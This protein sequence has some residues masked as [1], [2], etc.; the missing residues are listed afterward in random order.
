MTTSL[1]QTSFSSGE[2]APSLHA[3]TDLAKY[4]T[5]A[6]TLLN[7][8]VHA[9]GGASNRAGTVYVDTVENSADNTRLI[10]FQFS[11]TQSYILVFGDYTLRF[12]KDGA[13][14]LDGASP[15]E[16]ATPYAHTDLDRIH[17]AQ[18]ADVMYLA[19]PGY[20]PQKLSR[21]ADDNWTIA[22]V[23]PGSGTAAPANFARSVGTGT[24]LTLAVTATVNGEESVL[25]DT[26]T[27]DVADTVS[28]D[29]ILNVDFYSIYVQNNG[30][31]AFLRDVN[32]STWVVEDLSPDYNQ[33]P[34]EANNPFTT[35]DALTALSANLLPVMAADGDVYHATGTGWDAE[36]DP[37]GLYYGTL[38]QG[39]DQ[40]TSTYFTVVGP[41]RAGYPPVI[42]FTPATPVQ[43]SGIAF[44]A[45]NTYLVPNMVSKFFFEGYD[46]ADWIPLIQVSSQV[47]W[48]AA[49][50]RVFTFYNQ[51]AYE[52]YR[53]TIQQAQTATADILFA[54]IE[55][56][57]GTYT[58]ATNNPGTVVFHQQ[59]LDWA[60]TDSKPNTVFGSQ[61]GNFENHNT[62]YPLR[63]DDAFEF[64]INSNQVNEINWM[65]ALT[66]LILGTTGGEWQMSGGGQL[67]AI[68]P[69]NVNIVNQSQWGSNAI[70]PVRIGNTALFVQ[71]S[72]KV[73]RDLTFSFEVD[74]YT[75]NDLT[76]L[77]SHLFRNY[78]IRAWAYQQSPDSILWVVRE[79]GVL[80]GLTYIREH[81][82]WAW[83]RHETDG[84]FESVASYRETDGTDEVYF[85]VRRYIDGSYVRY[86]ERL[87]ERLPEDDIEQAFFVDCGL[88]LDAPYTITAATA[89]NPVV[90]TCAAHPFTNGQTVCI[91]DVVGMTELNG[92]KFTVANKATNTFELS[93]VDGSAYTAYQ[94]G[95]TARLVV[96]AV[97]GLD[98]LEGEDVAV[99]ADGGV[100]N[101]LTVSGGAITLP[102]GASI[103]HVG[104]PYTSDIETLEL[105]AP[106]GETILDKHRD[107]KSVTV[108]L[109]NTRAMWI[110][111]N[112][113]RLTEM[114]VRS[115]EDYGD[116]TAL[117]TG[118][119]EIIV[120]SGTT[121]TGKLFIRNVDP[122][123]ITVLAV[124]PRFTVGDA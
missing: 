18:S 5:G 13:Y 45:H 86:I 77:A 124:I 27:A 123:P 36:I 62:S 73:V 3:R 88:S 82:I 106:S 114:K 76:I 38:Y 115:W 104:L 46:G 113:D 112:A 61:T 50:K 93:G 110:G 117:V 80:L 1:M 28:W 111:P 32:V 12:I 51:T 42:T 108:A 56:Y 10:P 66:E 33:G 20:Q 60:R 34:P 6:K 44:T 78:G 9:H 71:G 59:R 94:S 122:L 49:E 90:V 48:T 23:S 14:V 58:A 74:G 65:T 89:A 11:V 103:V 15:Y 98:H 37:T 120:N 8:F 81:Q 16:I 22:A 109:E 43:I 101:G 55:F 19:H 53:V 63:D 97:S 69:S 70:Q 84:E 79:D 96:T 67:D 21:F 2:L 17:Y 118:N 72:G 68:T 85:V 91:R 119:K 87:A 41:L 107:I 100:V 105:E 39:L 99:L 40:D 54:N 4:S 7:M 25:S 47:G 102:N 31:W 75:G 83:H 64:T 26:D 29:S 24:D 57:T 35:Q 30:V 95:G 116:P 121:K 92:R 52:Q